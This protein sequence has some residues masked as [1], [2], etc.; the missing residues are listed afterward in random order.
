MNDEIE[1]GFPAPEGGVT[2]GVMYVTR[3]AM[4]AEVMQAAR[5]GVPM[6]QR[7]ASP[8]TQVDKPAGAV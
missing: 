4:L 7:P 8:W 1:Y 2:E 5:P 6:Y 3:N